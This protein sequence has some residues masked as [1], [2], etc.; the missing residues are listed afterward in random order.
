MGTDSTLAFLATSV[1]FI[2]ELASLCEYVGAD[3]REVER[4]LK[5]EMR[6]G[7]R[8]YL[9]PG[10]AFAGGTLARDVNFLN[11]IG[12]RHHFPTELFT[13]V[14]QSNQRHRQWVQRRITDVM[15]D[16]ANKT[17]AILGLT[18]KPGTDTLRR[19]ESI[20]TCKWLN[21]QGV[22]IKA[23]DPRITQLPDELMPFIQLSSSVSDALKDAD[24]AVIATEWPEFAELSTDVFLSSLRQPIVFDANG[25]LSKSLSNSHVT[26]FTVG[27]AS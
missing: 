25:Y 26:Y 19:S 4:G 11:Q 27:R 12:D 22:N 15:G 9:K 1:V 14:L 8:A 5:S 18:Y 24:A 2:N 13:A 17:V 3:A 16:I 7:S 21:Q 23:Y 10:N 6:I 20:E